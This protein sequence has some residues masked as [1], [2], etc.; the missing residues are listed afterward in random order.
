MHLITTY[1]PRTFTWCKSLL[2][3]VYISLPN[4]TLCT[5]HL[6]TLTLSSWCRQHHAKCCTLAIMLPI[7]QTSTTSLCVLS[8]F[9]HVEKVVSLAEYRVTRCD[10]LVNQTQTQNTFTRFS[11]HHDITQHNHFLCSYSHQPSSTPPKHCHSP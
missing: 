8:L 9:L 1:W 5:P 3:T 6:A 11:L 4:H 7:P 2:T 10:E